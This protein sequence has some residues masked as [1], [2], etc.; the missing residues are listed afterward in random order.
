MEPSPV[1]QQMEDVSQEN[2]T[3]ELLTMNVRDRTSIKEWY[4]YVGRS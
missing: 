1:D 2:M 3:H 4:Y